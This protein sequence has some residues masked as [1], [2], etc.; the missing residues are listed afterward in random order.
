[1]TGIY[2]DSKVR[3]PIPGIR[4]HNPPLTF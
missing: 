2:I 3:S 4:I 1:L